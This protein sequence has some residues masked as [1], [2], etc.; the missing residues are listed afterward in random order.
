MRYYF[1]GHV[2]RRMAERS[3]SPD[4][5]KAVIENGTVI[6]EYPDDTPCPSRLILGYDGTRPIHVVSSYSPT[7]DIERVI[8]AYEPDARLWSADFTERRT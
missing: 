1:S 2:L 4:A 8:T 7:D 3:I 5:I 6:R